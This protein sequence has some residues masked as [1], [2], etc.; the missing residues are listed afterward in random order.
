MSFIIKK[1]GI[2]SFNP[3][4]QIV[5]L[6][7][8]Q[9]NRA[10]VGGSNPGMDRQY[11]DC[12]GCQISRPVDEWTA[13]WYGNGRKPHCS[14]RAISK[15]TAAPNLYS[16][17]FSSIYSRVCWYHIWFTTK[18][19]SPLTLQPTSSSWFFVKYWSLC[20]SN[21][22]VFY[23]YVEIINVLVFLLRPVSKVTLWFVQRY[24]FKGAFIGFV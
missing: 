9:C 20:V 18:Y 3:Q 1:N 24:I 8:S 14:G 10:V 13:Q 17:S 19:A 22:C 23:R 12:R 6:I 15:E 5:Q 21:L 11:F 16:F 4:S 2:I 7:D